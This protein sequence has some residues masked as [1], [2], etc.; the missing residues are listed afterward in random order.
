[1]MEANGRQGTIDQRMAKTTET[2]K[3]AFPCGCSSAG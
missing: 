1:M 2:L 3:M